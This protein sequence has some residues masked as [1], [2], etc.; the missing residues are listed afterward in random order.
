MSEDHDPD[1]TAEFWG[2]EGPRVGR[3][4]SL[5]VSPFMKR[6]GALCAVG[7]IMVPVAFAIRAPQAPTPVVFADS[8][9]VIVTVSVTV[10][11]VESD[12]TSPAQP[13]GDQTGDPEVATAPSTTTASTTTGGVRIQSL[14]ILNTPAELAAIRRQELCGQRAY[15]VHAGDSW[16]RIAAAARIPVAD[17]LDVNEATLDTAIHPGDELCIPVG[18]QMPAPPARPTPSTTAAPSRAPAPRPAPSTASAPPVAPAG[19]RPS[20]D[21]VRALIREIWPAELQER[22]MAIAHRESRYRADAYNGWCCYGV[23]QI[24]WNVHRSWMRTHG[25][26]SAAQLLDARTN[27]EM[28]Y[29]IYQR[30]GGWGPWSQ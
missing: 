2:P 15:R 23:F 25:V 11:S 18:A 26:T 13:A 10:S 16:I 7:L 14:P 24:Y 8:E 27:I 12:P 28:A 21:Q 17:L 3:R 19:P 4:S 20:T 29:R 9:V 5:S 1:V 22:A 6:L 30:A